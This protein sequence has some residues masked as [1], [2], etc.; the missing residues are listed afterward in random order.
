MI[1]LSDFVVLP[2]NGS[3]LAKL[4]AETGFASE[5]CWGVSSFKLKVNRRNSLEEWST[6]GLEIYG[7]AIIS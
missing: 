3:E 5:A 7:L 1:V 2:M 6:R 4:Q